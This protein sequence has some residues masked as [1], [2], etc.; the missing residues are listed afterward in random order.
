MKKI[1]QFVV[2]AAVLAVA[3]VISGCQNM[4]DYRKERA[5]DAIKHFEGAKK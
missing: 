2:G 4:E 1:N 3:F 5:E